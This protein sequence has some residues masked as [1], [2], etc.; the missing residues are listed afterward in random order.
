MIS[1]MEAKCE[2]AE[3]L[4]KLLD[5]ERKLFSEVCYLCLIAW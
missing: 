4:K 2:E 1:I 5:K 3:S